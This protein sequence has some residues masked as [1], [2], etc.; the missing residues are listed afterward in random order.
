MAYFRENLK[1]VYD[2]CRTVQEKRNVIR[3]CIFGRKIS[4]KNI[5]TCI[6]GFDYDESSREVNSQPQRMVDRHFI[7]ACMLAQM[8]DEEEF[9]GRKKVGN[10]QQNMFSILAPVKFDVIGIPLC[11]AMIEQLQTGEILARESELPTKS[12]NPK[13]IFFADSVSFKQALYITMIGYVHCEKTVGHFVDEDGTIVEIRPS[14][15]LNLEP[16]E[17]LSDITCEL[18]KKEQ[19]GERKEQVGHPRSK[20]R[21]R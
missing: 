21:A 5:Y 2:D 14:R 1:P 15:I 18:L 13:H 16:K 8:I 7:I 11:E 10:R 20:K 12:V 17:E 6:Y 19:Q 9:I 3:G 4:Y